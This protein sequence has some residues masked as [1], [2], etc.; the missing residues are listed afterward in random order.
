MDKYK[1]MA[2]VE[3][4]E[5]TDDLETSTGVNIITNLSNKMQ[6]ISPT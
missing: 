6:T 1:I 5:A 3:G 2:Y 4:S